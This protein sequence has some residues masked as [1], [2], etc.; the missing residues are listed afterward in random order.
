MFTTKHKN[1][2]NA[3]VKLQLNNNTNVLNLKYIARQL[4][5]Y[6][7]LCLLFIYLHIIYVYCSASLAKCIFVNVSNIG[8]QVLS[9]QGSQVMGTKPWRAATQILLRAPLLCQALQP[10]PLARLT[11][12]YQH[13]HIINK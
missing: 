11:H 9:L 8:S 10:S 1:A 12:T 7:F 5:I 3:F 6:L 2:N 13:N 4:F